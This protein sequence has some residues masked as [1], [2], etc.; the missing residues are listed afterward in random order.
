MTSLDVT[1]G[2][3]AR[4]PLAQQLQAPLAPRVGTRIEAWCREHG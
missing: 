3:A 2:H 4:H 1:C